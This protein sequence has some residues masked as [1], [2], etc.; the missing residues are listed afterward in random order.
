[1]AIASLF[2]EGILDSYPKLKIV[3]SHGGDTVPVL[4]SV[5]SP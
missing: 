4:Y 3:V 2:Y 1:M 5:A